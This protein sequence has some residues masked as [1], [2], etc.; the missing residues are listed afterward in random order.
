MATAIFTAF[1][2]RDFVGNTIHFNASASYPTSAITTYQWEFDDGGAVFLTSAFTAEHAYSNYGIRHPS[3][4]VYEGISASTQYYLPDGISINPHPSIQISGIPAAG[5]ELSFIDA[6]GPYYDTGIISIE[7]MNFG[8]GSPTENGT[9][10]TPFF[11]TYSADGTYTVSLSAYGISGSIAVDTVD[12]I[13]LIGVVSAEKDDYITLCGGMKSNRTGPGKLINLTNFLPEYLQNSDVFELT[14]FFEDYLN[15]MYSG[16]TGYIYNEEVSAGNPDIATISYSATP[17]INETDP[18]ISILEKVKRLTEL[19]DINLIDSEYIQFFAKYLGYNVEINRNEIGGFGE[20]GSTSAVCSNA[21]SERYLRFVVSELPHWYKIKTTE[22]MIRVMLYSFGLVADIIQYYTKPYTNVSG[23]SRGY[24]ENFM[25]WKLDD[26]DQLSTIQDDWFPT[27]HFAV[28]VDLDKTVA[29]NMNNQDLLVTLSEQGD[30]IIKAIESVRPLNTVFHRLSVK[31]T[32]YGD[33]YADA[34]SRL[35]WYMRIDHDGYS[36]W[37]V[38]AAPP[39][40]DNIIQ[41]TI[42][43]EEI[44]WQDNISTSAD[45]IQ[46][47]I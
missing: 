32:E 33:I 1:K 43:S 22:D 7:K 42:D 17:S 4:I 12:I 38:S 2:T 20:F 10:T 41:D 34:Q 6:S 5:S 13:M 30:K 36:D 46:D 16:Y 3:L 18:R 26:T 14:K 29:T 28:K 44:T 9:P 15:E 23:D 47:S 21:D 31:T 39:A 8:D 24:D 25:N 37:W 27:P 45:T 35:S 11:H 19:H 40:P